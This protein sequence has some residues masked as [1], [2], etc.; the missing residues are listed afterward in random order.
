MS[1]THSIQVTPNQSPVA[2]FAGPGS[3][4]E[5]TQVSFP[6]KPSLKNVEFRN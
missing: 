3:A 6:L 2:L 4:V 1:R 5:D